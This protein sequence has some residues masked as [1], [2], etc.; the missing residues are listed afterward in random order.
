M[1][2]S[3]KKLTEDDWKITTSIEKAVSDGKIF[4]AFTEEDESRG[5]LR[6]SNV[7]LVMLGEKPIGTVSYELKDKDHAYIDSMTILPE[8]QGRGYASKALEWLLAKLKTMKKV[9]LVTHPYNS[10]AISIYLKHGFV[11]EGWKDNYF[12]DGE[13][14]VELVLQKAR[15]D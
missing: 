7:F 15:K 6:K 14:R 11:I 12:G 1:K 10:K 8:Y 2:L 9:D 5:Y 4:K 3:F 13:P